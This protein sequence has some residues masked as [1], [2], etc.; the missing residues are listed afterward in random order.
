MKSFL[1]FEIVAL[2]AGALLACLVEINGAVALT[3]SATFSSLMN[4][5]TGSLFGLLAMI[6]LFIGSKKRRQEV[7]SRV[8][9][10]K[11]NS[12][13]N[14]WLYLSGIAGALV[15]VCITFATNSPL[16]DVGALG[17]LF[18]G[19]ILAALLMDQMGWF[20]QRERMV[21]KMDLLQITL[22]LSGTSML[23]FYARPK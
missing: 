23:V 17:T 20:G 3:T 12:H 1:L 15:V 16:G 11:A 5:F 4:H 2:F 13:K 14:F 6:L 19:Q 9:N 8:A 18:L 7:L 21:S 10:W 22:I